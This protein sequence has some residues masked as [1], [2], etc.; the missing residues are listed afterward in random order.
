MVAV[1]GRATN[2][3]VVG[4]KPAIWAIIGA[5]AKDI[6]RAESD[7]NKN[8]SPIYDEAHRI[9]Q[10]IQNECFTLRHKKEAN[11]R[12]IL[13]IIKRENLGFPISDLTA[14]IVKILEKNGDIIWK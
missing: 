13:P 4:V 14:N 1:R 9:S 8:G 12:A 7:H 5:T 11:R 6:A 2:R 10:I 3:G